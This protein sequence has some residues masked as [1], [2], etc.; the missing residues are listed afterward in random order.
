MRVC[1]GVMNEKTQGRVGNGA[2]FVP[3]S[4]SHLLAHQNLSNEVSNLRIYGEKEGA[5]YMSI[6]LITSFILAEE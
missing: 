5:I 3:V 2:K 6:G 4:H 1:T